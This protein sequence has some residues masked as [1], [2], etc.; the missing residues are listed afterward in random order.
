M[1][2]QIV[3]AGLLGLASVAFVGA[4]R[5]QMPPPPSA[6]NPAI[7]ETQPTGPGAQ[8]APTRLQPQAAISEA[9]AKKRLEAQGYTAIRDLKQDNRSNWH[10]K[11]QKDGKS[12]DV[13]L[14]TSGAIRAR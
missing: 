3:A 12:V 8:G 7:R 14:D 6:T 10:A 13:S 11:A 5:A 4:A 9:D 1:N 2:R